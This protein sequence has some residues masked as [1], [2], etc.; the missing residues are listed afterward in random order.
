MRLEGRPLKLDPSD[1][2]QLSQWLADAV[3]GAE[4]Q[5][6]GTFI[7]HELQPPMISDGLSKAFDNYLDSGGI[8]QF[9][10]DHLQIE[11]I[12]G[13]HFEFNDKR[14]L[15]V[16]T[17]EQYKDAGLVAGRLLDKIKRLPFQYTTVVRG[18]RAFSSRTKRLDIRIQLS[19]RLSLVSSRMLKPTFQ[20]EDPNPDLAEW[21]WRHSSL[22]SEERQIADNYLYFVYRS[23]G[24]MP[25]TPKPRLVENLADELRSFYGACIAY[26]LLESFQ[27]YGPSAPTP[28]FLSYENSNPSVRHAMGVD[29]DLHE[30]T[31]LYQ[32]PSLKQ[33]FV[34]SES[35]EKNISPIVSLFSSSTADRIRTASIWLLRATTSVRPVDQVLEAAIAIEVLLGDRQV[36]DKVGLTRLMANR[37]AYALGSSAQ[38]RSEIEKTFTEFYNLRSRIVHDGTIH[39]SRSEYQL[40]NRGIELAKMIFVHEASMVRSN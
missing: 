8:V 6:W 2:Y 12:A 4:A 16:S 40:V 31:Y 26:G 21:Y 13:H 15:Q 30:A 27:E 39:P 24:Y 10:E 29:T 3:R 28:L 34:S 25:D 14:W 23:S 19:D 17:V 18:P 1:E 7:H 9:V 35:F 37:C 32:G 36:S 20:M 5:G 33:R 11:L 38:S 22:P